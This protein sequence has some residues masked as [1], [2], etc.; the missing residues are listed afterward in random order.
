MNNNLDHIRAY[1]TRFVFEGEN[2]FKIAQTM[3]EG[4]TGLTPQKVSGT[5]PQLAQIGEWFSFEGNYVADKGPKAGRGAELF[6]ARKIRPDLPITARGAM[7]LFDNTFS[8]AQHGITKSAITDF[9]AKYGDTVALKSETNPDILLEMS[10]PDFKD[11]ILETWTKRISARKPRRFLK[12]A[13]VSEQA[14]DAII[15]YHKDLALEKIKADPYGL[16]RINGVSFEDVDK[17]GKHLGIADDDLRRISAG[18]LDCIATAESSGSTIVDLEALTEEIAK[19]KLTIPHLAKFAKSK[20]PA[21]NTG[22]AFDAQ[23]EGVIIQSYD[24]HRMESFIAAKMVKMLVASQNDSNHER[25]DAVVDKVLARNPD[26]ARFDDIQKE[27]V[28]ICV[29][30]PIAILTGGPGTGKSTVTEAIVEC[31]QELGIGDIKPMA[32][33]GKAAVRLKETTKRDDVT[34]IH[35]SLE[36]RGEDGDGGFARNASNP[37]PKGSIIIIDESSMIDTKIAFALLQA[38]QE[39][40]RLLLVGDRWQLPSVG[41]GAFLSDLLM[42]VATNG[43]RIPAAELK[44]VYRSRKDSEIATGAVA[45]RNG[46]FD[47]GLVDNTG[48]GGV[49]FYSTR[50]SDIVK[51]TVEIVRMLRDPKHGI[52]PKRD[53]GILCPQ[54]ERV[55]GTLELNRALQ[56]ELNPKGQ[57]VGFLAALF[58]SNPLRGPA[59]R[60]GDRVM[61]TKNIHLKKVANGDVGIIIE[62]AEGDRTAKTKGHVAVALESGTTVRFTEAEARDLVVAYAITGHK[63]QGSQYPAVI[64]PMSTDFSKNML[65]RSLTYTMWTRAKNHLF[66]VGEEQAFNVSM[67]NTKPSQRST[68]LRHHLSKL[69]NEI[70]PTKDMLNCN[71]DMFDYAKQT[72]S[73]SQRPNTASTPPAAAQQPRQT[74]T[75]TRPP[76]TRPM[77]MHRPA[78]P[79]PVAAPSSTPSFR[80]PPMMR[81]SVTNP[82]NNR[83]QPVAQPAHQALAPPRPMPGRPMPAPPVQNRPLPPIPPRPPM[84]RPPMPQSTKVEAMAHHPELDEEYNAAPKF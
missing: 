36:A 82:M 20:Q 66:I 27:A 76:M 50:R 43:A 65:Y 2:G 12:E 48:R 11:V 28:R 34:T 46:S 75:N 24:Y 72:A 33:T 69:L 81:P 25:I 30:N 9:V 80:P 29:R 71:V 19:R 14:T 84:M 58:H 44:N 22:V 5:F 13:N 40:S 41:P 83:P 35:S 17:I 77:P 21:Q 59:P 78:M 74:P 4:S 51:Q 16:I 42:T 38:I 73:V 67:E 47:I 55:G 57:E 31:L 26:Y 39:G 53:I 23:A 62:A 3:Y 79:A 63:S 52:D 10:K 15:R 68:R 56:Q 32:P 37:Y 60:I 70:K 49:A 7:E 54:H 18:L 61:L 8:Y 64:M 45:V 1:V 6:K